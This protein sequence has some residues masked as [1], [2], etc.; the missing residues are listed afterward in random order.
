[1]GNRIPVPLELDDFEVSEAELVGG[2]LEVRVTSSFPRACHHCGSLEVMG[3]GRTLRRIRDRSFGHPTVLLWDQRRFRCTDCGRTCRERH[4]AVSGQRSVTERFRR[5]LFERACEQPFSQVADAE[6][7]TGYRVLEAFEDYAERELDQPIDPPR[8]ISL[9]ESSFK[10][11]FCFHTVLSDP[12]R[13]KLLGMVEGRDKAGAITAVGLLDPS[14]R[15]GVE[16]V[17]IDCHWPFRQAVEAM[18]PT[19]RIVADKF[20][21]IRSVDRAAQRV[22]IRVSRRPGSMTVG[23]DGGTARQKYPRDEPAL[24]RSRWVFMKRDCKLT[25]QEREWLDAVFEQSPE[26]QLAWLIKESFAAVY[27]SSDRQEAE[28]RLDTWVYNL[29]SC[30]MREFVD[31]WRTLQWWREPILAYFDDRMT[32]GFAEGITNKIKVMK[33]MSYG[34]RNAE[35]YQRKVLLM[36][37]R[38]QSR[39]PTHR[40]S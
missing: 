23:R 39:G 25:E 27:D 3:H 34:F 32:N 7:V 38:R 10:R 16:T 2:W 19:A 11:R 6:S 17:V 1:L 35:R 8:V 20:H 12:E 13:G 24:F 36:S 14:V 9:D 33:R 5:R 15:A 18:M 40:N 4:P 37:A 21:V 22:R 26:M 31:V 30:G 28:R 29:D